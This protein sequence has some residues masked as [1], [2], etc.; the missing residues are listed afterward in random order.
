MHRF[1]GL[2]ALVL[3]LLAASPVF[4]YVDELRRTPVV[5]AVEAVGPSVVS[6]TAVAKRQG[7][8]MFPND[9]LGRMLQKRFFGEL[10]QNNAS[11]LGSGVI[12]DGRAG[13]VLTNAHVIS[14]AET[15]TVRLA[16]GREFKAD[17]IG[18]DPDF[19][20]AVLRIK[21]ARNLPGVKLGD[22]DGILIGETVIAIGN[23]YGFSH[24]V[25]T[26]VVSALN[27]TIKTDRGRIGNFIQ[28]DAAINPGNSG[29]PLLNIKGELIGI[30]TAIHK[31]G[32]GIGFAIPVN[33]AKVVV[34]ELISTGHVAPI[35]LGLFG[36]NIDQDMALYFGLKSVDGMIIT[37]TFPDTPAHAAGIKAGDVLAGMN[38][39]A[40]RNVD[41]YLVRLRGH[42]K[43]EHL[44][45]NLLRDGKR[46]DVK[47]KPSVMSRETA[48][49]LV[50]KHWGLRLADNPKGRGAVITEVA[51]GSAADQA[52]LQPG[53]LVHQIGNRRLN[54]ADG[55]LAGYLNSRMS[56]TVVLRV[57]RG[58]GLYWVKLR[59]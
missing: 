43:G 56:G 22:S 33:K 54:S 7:R 29:G 20:L 50:A 48:A 24:T 38:G 1:A 52:H 26:G 39:R 10:P 12:I 3:T 8:S 6:I 25:T 27:R 53:D 44:T 49:T 16:D 14:G 30:N 34:A 13:L 59:R 58:R 17:M 5:K 15:I 31:E 40:L 4:A 35:W 37:E 18:S 19:D 46:M 36:Q 2:I 51:K 45:L 11:S 23:P 42:T 28:T 32:E 21:D 47:V 9:P 55:L 57:Q 41:D